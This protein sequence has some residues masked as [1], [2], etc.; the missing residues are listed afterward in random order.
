MAAV[1]SAAVGPQR[2]QSN[3]SKCSS[4]ANDDEESHRPFYKHRLFRPGMCILLYFVSGVVFY[5][6]HEGWSFVDAMYL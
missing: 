5:T 1:N 6:Q 2:S 3:R 4:A